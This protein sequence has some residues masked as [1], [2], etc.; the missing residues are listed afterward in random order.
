MAGKNDKRYKTR[1]RMNAIK[2]EPKRLFEAPPVLISTWEELGQLE[3]D[4]YKIEL[5]AD[6]CSGS[7]VSKDDKDDF[8]EYLSTHTFYE[9][10][11]FYRTIALR[12]LGFNIQL[13]NWHG[14]TVYCKH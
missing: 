14:E 3:N 4:K 5:D 13:K 1:K 12:K 6:K 9:D 11:Y 7:I 8:Y 2:H 10:T